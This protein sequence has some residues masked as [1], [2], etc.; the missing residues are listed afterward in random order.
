MQTGGERIAPSGRAEHDPY[1]NQSSRGGGGAGRGFRARGRGRTG[2]THSRHGAQHV[3]CPDHVP[4]PPSAQTPRQP[5]VS[6]HGKFLDNTTPKES[7]SSPIL[8][9]E[10]PDWYFRFYIRTDLRGFYH[11]YPDV[12]GP[13][14]SLQEAEN[15]IDRHLH[16]LE[17]PKMS[18]ESLEKLS[19]MERVVQE[20]LYWPDGTRKKS[21]EL[22]D[23]SQDEIHLLVQ[24]LVDQYNDDH[25]LLG[26]LA[27]Q[28]KDVQ[29]QR[30]FF[31]KADA[32]YHVNFTARTE[33]VVDSFFAE[34]KCT[35]GGEHEEMVVSCFCILKP[36][37]NGRCY[38]CQNNGS[39]DM[40]HPNK[41]DAYCRGQ[42]D[43]YMP[44][45]GG[46]HIEQSYLAESIEDEEKR[47]RSQFQCLDD[48]S[49]MAK[50]FPNR[51]SRA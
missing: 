11:T 47:L 26:D 32:Y 4:L 20:S 27:L 38:G 16:D 24:A 44:Y 35:H 42:V 8:V 23:E 19:L 6:C 13:F 39:V 28:L 41:A 15:A 33:G 43:E 22:P 18:S 46:Y 34:V 29:R 25:N 50:H 37:D 36:N 1:R 3:R 5:A 40:K 49:F 21:L 51:V 9:L 30:F 17:D 10:P 2:S 48:P 45:L 14:S 7:S 31:S 12:C